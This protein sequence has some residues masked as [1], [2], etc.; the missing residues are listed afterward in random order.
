V[1]FKHYDERDVPHEFVTRIVEHGN[2]MRA[3]Q[4]PDDPATPP[5]E[6]IAQLAHLPPFVRIH[7]WNLEP[8]GSETEISASAQLQMADID[9]NRHVAE[10]Q[11]NIE[12]HKRRQGIGKRL[13]NLVATAARDAE[14][15]LLIATSNDRVPTGAEFLAQHG[16]TRGIETHVNQLSLADLEPGLLSS[17]L[18]AAPLKAA[19]YEIGFWDGAYPDADLQRIADL[20]KVMN[21]APKGDLEIEDFN[22]TP[23]MLRQYEAVQF[24]NGTRRVTAYARHKPTGDFAGFTAL[25]WKPQRPGIVTQGETGVWPEHRGHGLGRWLKAANLQRLLEENPAARFVRTGNAD[26]NA[27][28]LSINHALGFKPYIATTVWQAQVGDVLGKAKTANSD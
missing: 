12:A 17:W 1:N 28:M 11:I 19:E 27:P 20:M 15:T 24:A 3:E 10:M 6:T 14:R 13:L 9:T 8:E 25:T 21:S 26:S 2:R 23:E 18:E 7:F 22:M 16:F 4:Q 5:A